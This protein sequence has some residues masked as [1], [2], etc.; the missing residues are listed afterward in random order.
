VVVAAKRAD[1]PFSGKTVVVTGTLSSMTR[2]EAKDR[3][4]AVGGRVSESVSK[5]T[6][7]LVCGENPGSK[8]Q[9]ATELGVEVLSEQ[10]LLAG[11]PT[12]V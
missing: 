10:A 3:I 5:K 6:D 8:L 11:S 2:D 1:H 9:K 7:F 4:R 12:A